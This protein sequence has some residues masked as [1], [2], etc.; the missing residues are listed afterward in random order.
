MTALQA[1]SGG[2]FALGIDYPSLVEQIAVLETVRPR[3]TD[4]SAEVG[5]VSPSMT[6]K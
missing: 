1:R 3:Q 2:N 6:S 4:S 5:S